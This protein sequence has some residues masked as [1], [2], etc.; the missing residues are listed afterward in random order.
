MFILTDELG[1]GEAD[2][3]L[4]P[5][6]SFSFP[7]ASS[8]QECI[9]NFFKRKLKGREETAMNSGETAYI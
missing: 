1:N 7:K 8:K 9:Y 3:V 2:G 6:N 5:V 4:L